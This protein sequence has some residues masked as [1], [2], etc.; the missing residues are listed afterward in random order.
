MIFSIRIFLLFSSFQS[1]RLQANMIELKLDG[2][3]LTPIQRICQYPLQ[4]NQLLKST[5]IE[6]R[7]Y[8]NVQQAVDAMRDVASYINEKKRQVE[9]GEIMCK[10]QKTIENWQVRYKNSVEKRKKQS[11][12]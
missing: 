9:Y 5:P 10:W 11:K 2:F 12:F 1:C 7:D 4:L 3:L 8:Q 6:H